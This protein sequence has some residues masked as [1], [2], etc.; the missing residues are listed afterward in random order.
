M[1]I[2][3]ETTKVF[4]FLFLFFANFSLVS[5][6]DSIYRLEPGTKIRVSMDSEINSEVSSVD[7][8]FTTTLDEPFKV[9]ET[10]VLPVGTVIEGRVIKVQP[11]SFSGKGGRLTV[12]FETIRFANG[13]KRELEGV[14]AN[15]LKADSQQNANLLT[16]IGGTALGA[17]IGGASKSG[18]GAMIG[19][20]LG[21]GLGLG[22]VALRK[23][24]EM[25]IRRDEK[26]EVELTSRLN[27]PVQ[28]Y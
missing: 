16:V 27:L 4:A 15:E 17:L 21:A 6:Q 13:E 1:K 20:G 24:K 2:W 11:A 14:L 9:R 3:C 18:T 10:I 28:D 7:D 8:T 26:F 12:R 19:A 5:A 23:G 25:R 22:A